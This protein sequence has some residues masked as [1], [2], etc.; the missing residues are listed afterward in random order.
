MEREC[1]PEYDNESEE[2][3]YYFRV[4][5]RPQESSD[6]GNRDLSPPQSAPCEPLSS[7]PVSEP[8]PQ[9]PSAESE[10]NPPETAPAIRQ[11][12]HENEPSVDPMEQDLPVDETTEALGSRYRTSEE[13]NEHQFIRRKQRPLKKFTYDNFGTPLC[14][15][16]QMVEKKHNPHFASSG[17]TAAIP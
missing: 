12:C 3:E 8:S 4:E 16:V 15:K 6:L 1:E 13:E 2:D 7:P 10:I 5:M 14:Y 11:E 9:S 17:I